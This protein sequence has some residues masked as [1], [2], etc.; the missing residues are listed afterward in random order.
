MD[1]YALMKKL[2]DMATAMDVDDAL[3]AALRGES[4]EEKEF[5][6]YIAD[7]AIRRR[8]K[9]EMDEILHGGRANESV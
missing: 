6:L 5:Y 1:E 9:A 3:V 2:Y 4:T 8:A 7:M